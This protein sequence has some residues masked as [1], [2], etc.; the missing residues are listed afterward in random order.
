MTREEFIEELSCYELAA[1]TLYNGKTEER[2]HT[3]GL[4]M[5]YRKRIMEEFDRLKT[6]EETY[7]RPIP[8]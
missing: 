5:A 4:L 7:V 2:K 8:E 1:T 6:I 3:F